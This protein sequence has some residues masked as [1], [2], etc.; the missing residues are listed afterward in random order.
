VFR[1]SIRLP[2]GFSVALPH[3][4]ALT[5]DF[6]DYSAHY[7]VKD[8]VLLAERKMIVKK[9]KVTVEQWEEYR[10]FYKGVRSD[11]DQFL[12]LSEGG[13]TAAGNPEAQQLVYQ[14]W[15]SVQARDSNAARDLLAQAERLNPE[16]AWLWSTYAYVEM[17][18]GNDYQAIS[19]FQ[20]EIEYHPDN[21]N[22]YNMLSE[23]LIHA[24]RLDDAVGMWRSALSKAPGDDFIAR[25]TANTMMLA[26]RYAD[27]PAVLEKPIAA[28]PDK[29]DLQVFR[30]EAWLRGG[31]KG[32]GVEEARKIAKATSDPMLLNNLSFALSDTDANIE[33]ARELAEKAVNQ[34]EQDCA[35]AGLS[36]VDQGGL[37]RVNSLAA[38]WDTLGWAFFKDGEIAKAE[39]YADAAWQLGQH[40]A[41]ADHLGEIYYKQGRTDAA[42]HMWRLALASNSNQESAREHLRLAGAPIAAPVPVVKPSQHT[43]SSQAVRRVPYRVPSLV[44]SPAEELGKLRTTAIPELPKQTGSAEFYLLVSQDGIQDVRFIGGSDSLKNAAREI[45]ASKYKFPFPDA[46][47]EKIVRRGILSCSNYTEPSCQLTLLLPST[48]GKDNGPN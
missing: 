46:G 34:T 45:R 29:Y 20:K 48:V 11:Q 19:D 24:G 39:K 4:A 9:P 18:S 40:S 32:R 15:Q 10:K 8:G 21:N 6:A 37:A 41:V 42:V 33:L 1:A 44:V 23:L 22:A 43:R 35:K 27:L 28:A 5:S 16:Q 12:T 30:A 7:S 2:K 17:S 36:S 47:S 31:E 26:K 38:E 25:R 3:D 14:A 13:Q